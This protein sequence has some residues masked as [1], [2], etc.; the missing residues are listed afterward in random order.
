MS[1]QVELRCDTINDTNTYYVVDYNLGI[2][3]EIHGAIQ[4]KTV[5][6]DGKVTYESNISTIDTF[7]K[8]LAIH[9]KEQWDKM[10]KELGEGI[11]K[12]IEND[13]LFF[14]LNGKMVRYSELEKMRENGEL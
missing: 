5:D 2:E 8:D 12:S 10:W 7:L 11:R 1:E 3:H 13:T 9:Q 14:H 6:K 4:F